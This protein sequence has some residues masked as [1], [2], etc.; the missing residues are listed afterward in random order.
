[1][2][3]AWNPWDFRSLIRRG[4]LEERVHPG[5]D[6]ECWRIFFDAKSRLVEELKR[7]M[8]QDAIEQKDQQIERWEMP[9]A[10]PRDKISHVEAESTPWHSQTSIMK[11]SAG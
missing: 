9:T 10:G 6:R 3:S 8:D 2:Q 1:M 7:R 5:V 11:Q 4:L